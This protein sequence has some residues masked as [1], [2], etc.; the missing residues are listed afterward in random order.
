MRTWLAF[1]LGS[2]RIVHPRLRRLLLILCGAKVGRVRMKS[3]AVLVGKP[4]DLRIGDSFI[5]VG[6]GL[7]AKGGII[8]GDG[9][10]IAPRV[11]ILTGTHDLGGHKRRATNPASFRP[12]TIGDGCWIGAGVIIQPG[13]TVGAGCVIAAGSVVTS[14]CSPDGLYAG[15][16]AERKR[17][18]EN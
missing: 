10:A 13:V 9:V 7:F 12:V 5:N 11:T 18:L 15:V 1:T 8:I 17:N 3:N 6:V 14:D 4:S 16:P 2:M